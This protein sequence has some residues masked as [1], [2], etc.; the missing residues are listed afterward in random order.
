V[1]QPRRPPVKPGPITDDHAGQYAVVVTFRVAEWAY[2]P[3][4]LAKAIRKQLADADVLMLGELADLDIAVR[5]I[6]AGGERS[7]Q[8]IWQ[9]LTEDLAPVRATENL[10]TG[11]KT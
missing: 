6:G 3:E 10:D 11:G 9:A 1:T 4:T 8:E 5:R 2:K 7:E